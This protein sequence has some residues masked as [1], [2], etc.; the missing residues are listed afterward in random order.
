MLC[1]AID[2]DASYVSPGSVA[3]SAQVQPPSGQRRTS[4]VL[5]PWCHTRNYYGVSNKE[6]IQFQSLPQSE[7]ATAVKVFYVRRSS[8]LRKKKYKI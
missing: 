1:P 7:E 2:L 3:V 5:S 4:C 8:G 6:R